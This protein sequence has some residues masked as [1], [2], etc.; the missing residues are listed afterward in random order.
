MKRSTFKARGKPMRKVSR[1]KAAYRASKA[2]QD[3]LAYMGKVKGLPCCV[4]GAPPPSEA[5]HCRSEGM[6]RDD[7]NTIPLC[8][9]CHRG[10]NGY[11]LAKRSWH[12]A[13]GPDHGYIE[14]TRRMVAKG[15]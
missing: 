2:G 12:E 3:A 15:E 4:C 9:P 5:H 1:K 10:P 13:N 14:Q 8:A 6:A 7:W 11:H